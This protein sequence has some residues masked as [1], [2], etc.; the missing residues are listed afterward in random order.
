MKS[1]FYLLDII[2]MNCRQ[3]NMEVDL[4]N[5]NLTRSAIVIQKI[6]ILLKVILEVL[7]LIIKNM[8]IKNIKLNKNSKKLY[9][10]R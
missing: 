5:K 1:I 8:M 6:K 3:I 4:F 10:M 2:S 9:L 7:I